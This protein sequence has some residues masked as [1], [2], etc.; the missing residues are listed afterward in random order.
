MKEKIEKVK[1]RRWFLALVIGVL[2]LIPTIYSFVFL[3]AYWDPYGR[4]DQVPV[5]I[6]NEDEGKNGDNK[7]DVITNALLDK[8]VLDLQVE[9][10]SDAES[11][12]ELGRVYATF[13]IPKDFTANLMS[14]ETTDKTTATVVFSANQ[15][16]NYVIS[17]LLRMVSNVV[18]ESI[19][20]EASEKIVL[21]LSQKLQQVPDQVQQIDDGLIQLSD[22]A[23]TLQTSYGQ[24]NDGVLNLKNGA[25][26]LAGGMNQ[27]NSGIAT[28]NSGMQTLQAGV[29]KLDGLVTGV[30]ALRDGAK[31]YTSGVDKYTQFVSGLVGGVEQFIESSGLTPPTTGQIKQVVCAIEP[32]GEKCQALTL[33]IN[34]LA[35]QLGQS[36]EYVESLTP[37]NIATVINQML[38]QGGQQINNGLDSLVAGT[39]NLSTLQQGV[40]TLATGTNT[41]ATGSQQV[42]D[43]ANTLASGA[44]TLA[45]ASGKVS[46][47]IR[48]LSSGLNTAENKVS[49][50]LDSTKI[51][52]KKLD[53]LPEFAANPATVSEEPVNQV[54]TYGVAFAPFFISLSLWVGAFVLFVVLYSDRN[55]RF[56]NCDMNAT[57]RIK[58]SACY[59]A[60]A[61][62]QGLILGI[63]IKWSLGL[64]ITNWGLYLGSLVLIS[65]MFEAI[66]EFLIVC[67]DDFGKFVALILL[68][69]Q[70]AASGGTFPIEVVSGGFQWLY[71]LLP[72]RYSISL[73]KECTVTINTDTLLPTL[74]VIST[75]TI[76][77]VGINVLVGAIATKRTLRKQATA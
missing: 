59:M 15:K 41:L 51:E 48:Q 64:N 47:G 34:T 17:Q 61:I 38:A 25:N 73:L 29:M 14:A 66:I 4:L 2:M 68:I 21:S 20:S 32:S 35:Q 77:F 6:V 70:V 31:T 43:G 5:A 37:A 9:N 16:S 30:V 19:S 13:T 11:D 71:N 75:V 12:L 18:K 24:F 52:L 33:A 69:I 42:T 45:D 74:I 65:A 55:H 28:L 57:N 58:R 67:L 72:M 40:N 10:A 49:S 7:G 36:V 63:I 76:V 50:S 23:N 56:K 27:L 8:N 60:A 62:A 22:G 1:A 53:G 54:D 3:Q 26:T 44:D 39:A 46:D